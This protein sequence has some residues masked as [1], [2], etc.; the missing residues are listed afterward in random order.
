MS[1]I[2]TTTNELVKKVAKLHQKKFRNEFNLF[3]IEG[4]KA[5]DEA[6]FAGIEIE[7]IFTLSGTTL[8]NHPKEV[9]VS[10]AVMKKIST[11]QSPP[12]VLAVAKI[13]PKKPFNYNKIALFENI[14][15]PGNLGTII[16]S[17]TAFNIDAIV[18]F[19]DSIDPY[20]PKVIRSAAGNFFKVP[21]FKVDSLTSFKTYTK[22][23]TVV[24]GG[25][26]TLS[27]LPE[28]LIVMFGSEAEGLSS[29]LVGLADE[30]YTLPT[31]NRAESLN[32]SVAA[33]IVF[34]QMFVS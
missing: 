2:K 27:S 34:Y 7:N 21:I 32:L 10:E 8:K 4:E 24:E 20:N 14:K 23:A 18:L 3:I 26:T 29:E 5:V 33:S 13:P 12:P 9:V 25:Q 22:I 16:R 19:G 1:E 30:K 6:L 17:A 31:S 28:K 11:T 15:D